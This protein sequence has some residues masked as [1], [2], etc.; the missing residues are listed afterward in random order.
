MIGVSVG[1]FILGL[2]LMGAMAFAMVDLT[3][4]IQPVVME[5]EYVT[6]RIRGADK[7]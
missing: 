6:R 7:A 5:S 2:A 1:F 3:I 4:A